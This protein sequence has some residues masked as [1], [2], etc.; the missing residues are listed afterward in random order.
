MSEMRSGSD[1]I[2]AP[3]FLTSL[4][5]FKSGSCTSQGN[6]R[7]FPFPPS[8]VPSVPF[9][10]LPHA[11]DP[12]YRPHRAF[13][14]CSSILASSHEASRTATTIKLAAITALITYIC[15]AFGSSAKVFILG[16]RP[17]STCPVLVAALCRRQGQQGGLLRPETKSPPTVTQLHGALPGPEPTVAVLTTLLR[18]SVT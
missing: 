10:C 6:L 8:P 13:F 2:R 12:S 15:W 11:P 16:A 18:A 17:A 1:F 4:K 9:S 5:S 7:L 14:F 3:V